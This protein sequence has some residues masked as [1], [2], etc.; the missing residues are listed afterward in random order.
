MVTTLQV[1]MDQSLKQEA[2]NVFQ[3]I[4]VDATTAVRM[5]YHKVISTRSIPF[6]LKADKA[7]RDAART[8]FESLILEG[9]EGP[10][11]E[12]TPGWADDAKKRLRERM[13]Q[14][15]KTNSK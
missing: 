4:G 11:T 2:E 6:E 7:E 13:K 5:F 15:P 8:R 1:R 10:F 12:V 14:Q 3:E 9:M